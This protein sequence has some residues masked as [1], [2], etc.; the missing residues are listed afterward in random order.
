MPRLLLSVSLISLLSVPGSALAQAREPVPAQDPQ[1]LQA[2]GEVNWRSGEERSILMSEFWVP[3]VQSPSSVMF[4]MLRLMGDDNDAREGNI[5]LGYRSI[6]HSPTFSMGEGVFGMHGWLDRRITERGSHF[7]QVTAGAEWLGRAFDMRLN[8]YVP[9]SDAVT[10]TIPNEDPQGASFSGT[11][12]LIDTD[13]T[14]IE[15]PQHGFDLELGLE[16][17]TWSKT[18]AKHTDGVRV[19]AGGYYFDGD[20]TESVAGWRTR[21]AADITQD[22]QI[23]G[24][25]QRDDVRGTQGFI[26]ATIRFPFG[27]KKSY[28]KEGLRA[29]L[30]TSVER[31]IDIVTAAEITD[32]GD[33][34]PLINKETGAPQEILFVDNSAANGGD[35][36][37]ESPFNHLAEAEGAASAHT[38]IYLRSGDGTRSNQDRGI[39]LNKEGQQLI[40]EGS[41]FVFD[42]DRFTTANGATP[43]SVVIAKAGTAPVIG[44]LDAEEDGV[45]IEAN[46]VKVAGITVDNANI[47]RD[48][49]VVEADGAAKS[50][51]NV[52]IENVTV[53]NN[54]MGIYVHG[55]NG[56]AVSA[57]VQ[58]SIAMGNSQHGIAVYDDTN[59]AFEVD[60][61]GGS[62]GSA[63]YNVLAGN[64]LEDLAVEYDGRQLSA[65]NNWWGQASGAYQSTPSGTLKPQIYYGAPIND[66]LVSHY[67]LDE[68][69]LDGT[70]AYDRSVSN[71]NGTIAGGITATDTVDC[72]RRQ[73]LQFDAD[74]DSITYTNTNLPTNEISVLIWVNQSTHA[75]WYD[76]YD[77]NWGGASDPESWILL[78]D[79]SERP[80]FGFWGA[81]V[82]GQQSV[83][84]APGSAPLN[85]W[86][87]LVGTYDGTTVSV[88]INA[89]TPGSIVSPGITFDNSRPV[90]IGEDG[91]PAA[92]PYL[93]DE[94]RIYSRALD[95]AEI[96]ELYRMNTSSSVNTG[97]FLTSDP[98]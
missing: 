97:G 51:Q 16:L 55:T 92:A 53:T 22:I 70:T 94:A 15:E 3:F 18:L 35:G 38:I 12:I 98:E 67:T 82:G 17:G 28:R 69:W 86:N 48:G 95:P 80:V 74:D 62:M 73:C 6:L 58:Q 14:L 2:R 11:S 88:S 78:T 90:R 40:G 63:G 81:N 41:A 42:G 26:E 43:S 10:H 89:G 49:I 9:L 25:L 24:R 39:T 64:R 56:G 21:I 27:A 23:G 65:Q 96:S 30:D 52:S 61:G 93:L 4:G 79:V 85:S 77:N 84:L 36:S 5:G 1:A 32:P 31:D 29:R 57:K 34:V 46:N 47:G 50:A 87:M 20:Y 71:V 44:N 13:G 66:D 45:R 83:G 68:E 19:Y 72:E 7:H 60:L 59:G 8:G 54:R 91:T 75:N 37:N 76:F 33:R